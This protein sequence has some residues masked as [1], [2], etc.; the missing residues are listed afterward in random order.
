MVWIGVLGLLAV[1]FIAGALLPM[2]VASTGA[3][4]PFDIGNL[5]LEPCACG[6]FDMAPDSTIR[7]HG[8]A[9]RPERCAWEALA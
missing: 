6:A 4:E 3:L 8:I 7:F 5:P 2:Y 9:H 1:G